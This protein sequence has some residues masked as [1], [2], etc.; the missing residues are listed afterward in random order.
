MKNFEMVKEKKCTRITQSGKNYAIN[1]A[2]QGARVSR[3]Q[4][5]SLV[6]TK[7]YCLLGSKV[8]VV[9]LKK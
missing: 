5:I 6:L 9:W 3:K 2:M 7:P 4:K 8:L 1:Y